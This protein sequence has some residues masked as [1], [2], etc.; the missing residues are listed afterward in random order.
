MWE[1]Q[2]KAKSRHFIVKLLKTKR[3]KK[4]ERENNLKSTRGGENS[5][6]SQG[7]NIRKMAAFLSEIMQ[8]RKYWNIFKMLK[9]KKRSAQQNYPPKMK[10]E[11]RHFFLK[12]IFGCVGSSFLCEGFL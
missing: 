3:K 10:I 11:K 2:R 9:K 4:R 8:T 1:I 7:N 5:H 6:Y 12:F